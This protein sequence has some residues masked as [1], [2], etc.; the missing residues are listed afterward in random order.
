[1]DLL[2]H[3]VLLDKNDVVEDF[4]PVKVMLVLF[5]VLL[6]CVPKEN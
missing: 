3:D 1:M 4:S 6:K 5:Y 2:L